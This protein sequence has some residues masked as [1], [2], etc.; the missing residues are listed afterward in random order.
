MIVNATN[1]ADVYKG[2]KA[3]FANGFARATPDYEK[4]ATVVPSSTE[5]NYYPFLGQFPQMRKWLG[6]R[7]I[8][9]LS[10]H[11]YSL[12]NEPY[13]ATVGVPR[14]KIEDDTYGVFAPLME[15]M[16]Y[17]SAMHPDSLV[18]AIAAAGHSTLCY[19]G[20]YFLDD[21]HPVIISGAATTAD[22]YDGSGG[23][24]LWLLLD[25]RRPLK[26]FIFQKRQDYKFQTFVSSTDEHVF[27]KNEFLYGIDARV[28]AG[29]GLWQ[30]A[31]GSLNDLSSTNYETYL[32][33][34]IAL[35][36][37]EGKPLGIR[38]NLCVV[39][40]SHYQEALTLFGTQLLSGGGTNP[41]YKECEVLLTPY[42]D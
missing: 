20:Q 35:K 17:E 38:P 2:Y 7:Q 28:C 42:L 26:P 41:H 23:H 21:D 25:T 24:N 13:E 14:P 8:K 32:A 22:N 29:V 16:G 34:M 19:D 33:A 11:V 18:F 31:Y 12:T 15:E 36:S 4:V 1:L 40:P 10:A 3:N 27:M 37:D 9:N 5:S 6:D 39:G 30:L